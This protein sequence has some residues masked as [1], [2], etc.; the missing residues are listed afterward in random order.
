MQQWLGYV[1]KYSPDGLLQPWPDTDYRGWY[2]GDWAVPEGVNQK[3]KSSVDLVNNCVISECFE[4]MGKIAKVLGKTD[5]EKKYSGQNVQLKQLIHQTFFDSTKNNYGSGSQIDLTY[6][7]LRQIVPEPLISSVTD[8]LYTVIKIKH[9]GNIACGLVGIP[10]FT[11]WAIKNHAVELFYTMLKKKDYPGY[12]YMMDNGA[13]TTWE[14][15]SGDRSRI[16]NCYNGIG[17]WFYQAVGGIRPDTDFPGYQQ[18]F[19]D[20]QI[21]DGLTWAKTTKETPYG[22]VKVDWTLEKE[23]LNFQLEIPVGCTAKVVL[24]KGSEDYILNGK[25]CSLKQQE[26]LSNVDVGSGKYTL[27]CKYQNVPNQVKNP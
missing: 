21:P 18:V 25:S 22:T 14:H 19:I 27:S 5:D 10:V 17:S 26:T 7:L 13:T 23:K 2:L 1:A 11:E 9:N 12:L 20:P 24:P 8:S 15:W 16:H 4:T 3:D 6:P